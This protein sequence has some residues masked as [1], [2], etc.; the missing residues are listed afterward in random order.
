MKSKLRFSLTAGLAAA[1]MFVAATGLASAQDITIAFTGYATDQPFWIGVDNAAKAEAEAQGVKFIDLTAT[2]AD[3][4]AQKDA[5]DRA[6]GLGVDGIIIGAVDNR[7]FDDTLAKAEA[8]GIPVVTVDTAIEHPWIKSLVQTDNLAAAGLAGKYIVEHA[9]PGTV[10]ILGGSE[11]HQT[12]NARRD[13][14]MTAAEAAGFKVIF[15]ICDWKDDCAYETTL[16]QTKANPDITAIFSAWDPGALAAVSAAKEN[17]KLQDLVIVGFDGN[18]G[19]L[20]SI[21]AGEQ[22]ATVKQD[23]IRMGQESVRNLLAIIKGETVAPFTGIDGI[24]IDK[25]N[26]AEFI[27]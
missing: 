25:A 15:Q 18:P 7:G 12:G 14:V 3:A 13:G 21:Q 19:N 1:A 11:G 23:N 16:T 2:Q 17:G 5:V 26:V 24:L 10:L 9:K 6:I 20:A 8:A 22:T 4:A 27:K